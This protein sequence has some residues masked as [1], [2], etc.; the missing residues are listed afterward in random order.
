MVCSSRWRR[1]HV[2]P[3]LRIA[4]TTGF[5]GGLT[6]YSAF[7]YETLRLIESRAYG[8]ALASFV[9][10]TLLCALAGLLGVLVARRFAG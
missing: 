1:R 10:T 3:T 4:L 6:T 7:N 9:A 8:T 5:M 2:S